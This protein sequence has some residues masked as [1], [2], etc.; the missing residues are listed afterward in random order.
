MYSTLASR[1][2]AHFNPDG[3]HLKR[4]I[5]KKNII[6]KSLFEDLILHDTVFIPITDF[7]TASGLIYMLGEETFGE[8]IGLGKIKFIRSKG[9]FGYIR[10]SGKDGGL[11]TFHDPDKKRPQDSPIDESVWNGLNL[12]K[13][14]LSNFPKTHLQIIENTKEIEGK[15]ILEGIK[16]ET[17]EDF[18]NS[19]FWNNKYDFEKKDLLCFLG[20]DKGLGKYSE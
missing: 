7:V 1:L 12:I 6:L 2:T 17:T 15:F 10:G 9:I 19:R 14:R 11:V 5:Q 13:N 20:I 16:R 8:L 3:L 18:R 4:Y